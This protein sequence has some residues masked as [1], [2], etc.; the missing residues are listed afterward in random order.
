MLFLTFLAAI[1][2]I[3]ILCLTLHIIN[4]FGMS[5]YL[6]LVATINVIGLGACFKSCRD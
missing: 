2:N 3:T 1:L 5:L 4:T 6:I